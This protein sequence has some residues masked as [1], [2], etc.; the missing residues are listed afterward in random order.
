MLE[1]R[2]WQRLT[3]LTVLGYE[4]LGSLLGGALRSRSPTAVTWTCR[5]GS[6]TGRSADFLIPGIILLG[7][8]LLNVAAFFA[9][10]RRRS[11]DWL[12][13]GL[14][15]GGLAI[16]FLVEIRH[17]ARAHWLHAMWGFPVILGLTV[18]IPLLPL[19]QTSPGSAGYRRKHRLSATAARPPSIDMMAALDDLPAPSSLMSSRWSRDNLIT[20]H[21]GAALR[22]RRP[23]AH[24]RG[25]L[26]SSDPRS[27]D[28]TKGP[29]HVGRGAHGRL[30]LGH[31][32]RRRRR[33]LH[34]CRFRW[35]WTSRERGAAR[36]AT[37]PR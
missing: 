19:T 35:C 11:T 37:C 29:L 12:W 25:R 30:H 26:S 1:Q 20:C 27:R 7:L 34:R 13:A 31:R 5:S 33:A 18:A 24:R 8:G 6:C 32:L 21:P 2:R 9:V 10:L 16:W 14:A 36:S 15:L 22:R 17:P 3:L 28:A 23:R 4:G